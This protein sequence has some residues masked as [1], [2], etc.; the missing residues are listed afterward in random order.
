MNDQKCW[1]IDTPCPDCRCRIAT[2]ERVAEAAKAFED[3]V[4]TVTL[5]GGV[6]KITVNGVAHLG[7]LSRALDALAKEPQ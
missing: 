2:L 4:V 6:Y 7:E 3:S 5:H 1:G